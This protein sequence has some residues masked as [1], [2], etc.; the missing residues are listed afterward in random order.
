M[1]S[2]L[3]PTYNYD[4]Y[5]LV[6]ELHRQAT[7]LNIEFEIIVADDCSNTEL[8]RLQLINQ[9]S[10]SKLIKPQ[11]N[12]GRAKIRNFLA[13]KSHYNYLLFLDSDSY[14]ADN[15]F[16]KKYFSIICKLLR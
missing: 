5:D 9:L 7:E 12:L 11:H 16:I 8:S 3:I 15:N 6:L 1:L 2:I 13:D 14:P 10:N 4:C